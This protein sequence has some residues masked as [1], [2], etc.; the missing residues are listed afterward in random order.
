MANNCSIK[1]IL[2]ISILL[3]SIIPLEYNSITNLQEELSDETIRP[4]FSSFLY[5]NQTSYYFDLGYDF[6]HSNNRAFGTFSIGNSLNNTTVL[7]SFQNYN[8][9]TG[10]NYGVKSFNLLSNQS[11]GHINQ[12]SGYNSWTRKHFDTNDNGSIFYRAHRYYGSSTNN[13]FT[14]GSTYQNLTSYNSFQTQNQNL[15]TYIRNPTAIDG[16]E[17]YSSSSSTTYYYNQGSSY[18]RETTNLHAGN[19]S[20]SYSSCATGFNSGAG[21]VVKLVAVN[22]SAI[23][24]QT[25]QTG[26]SCPDQIHKVNPDLGTLEWSISGTSGY[27]WMNLVGFDPNHGLIVSND[28]TSA[29]Y[30]WNTYDPITGNK[31]N[32][33]YPNNLS[34]YIDYDGALDYVD[35]AGRGY[36]QNKIF[37]L[38]T[39]SGFTLP[40]HY[41]QNG[42]ISSLGTILR[43]GAGM[44]V[45]VMHQNGTAA[46][47]IMDGDEDGVL[48]Y[49]FATPGDQCLDSPFTING[50]DLD[51]DGCYSFEDLDDD[52]DTI[53]DSIDVCVVISTGVDTD[54]DGC[55]DIFDSDD[56]NDG[57]EDGNESILG[58]DPLIYDTDWDGVCDG[59]ISFFNCTAGPDELPLEPTQ[60]SDQ[61]EDGW[62]DNPLG[63]NPDAF[64]LD[65]NATSDLDGDGMPDTIYGNSTTGLIEDLDDDGDGILDIYETGTGVYNGTTDMGTDSLDP[66]TDDDNVNDGVDLAPLDFE[67]SGPDTDGDGLLDNI[68]DS[69]LYYYYYPGYDYLSDNYQNGS[70]WYTAVF[71]SNETY[72]SWTDGSTWS[73]PKN[74]YS[75]MVSRAYQLNTILSG[76]A[77]LNFRGAGTYSISYNWTSATCNFDLL[78]NG[79][80]LSPSLGNHTLLGS[81]GFGNNS[82][83]FSI[84]ELNQDDCD[85]NSVEIIDFQIPH[86]EITDLGLVP[87][88]DDDND[89]FSDRIEVEGLCNG[90]ISDPLSNLS[91]PPDMD[92]DLICDA[93]DDDIDGD[94]FNNSVDVF[95]LDSNDWEDLDGDGEG[96]NADVDDDG[97][98]FN[99]SVDSWPLG[100]CVSEDYDSDGL[101]D[102]IVMNCNTVVIEDFDDDN[103]NKLDQDDFCSKGDLNWLSGAVTDHDQ[104]GCQDSGEDLDDDNDGLED[105]NDLCPKGHVGWISNPSADADADGCHD[106]IEDND[107]DNDGVTEPGDLCP[108]TPANV[109][110]DANGCPIDLDGDGVPDYLDN[111]PNTMLGIQVDTNGCPIDSDGDGVPDFQDDFP[112]DANETIDSDGDGVGDNADAFPNDPN[113]TMDSDGD[114]Y[115][116]NADAFPNNALEFSDL[117]GDGV[118]GNTDVFPN[119]ANETLDSDLDEVGDNSDVFPNDANETMDSDGDGVGDNSDVFPDD[120]SETTDSDGDGVGDTSD[121]FPT[122]ANETVDSDGDGI[123]DSKDECL[124]Q[125]SEEVGAD[126]C[127]IQ[128]STSASSNLEGGLAI[129]VLLVVAI[130]G[131]VVGTI[132]MRKKEEFVTEKIHPHIEE[133][134]SS[135][136]NVELDYSQNPPQNSEGVLGDDGYHWLE[137]PQ[138]SGTWY[139]RGTSNDQWTLFEQ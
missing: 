40:Y 58:S 129:G 51:G 38:A 72:W 115:G 69:R 100:N 68:S 82:L 47:H 102:Y 77:E 73:F 85:E 49:P 118:G 92:G 22:K 19:F 105:G 1:S 87:D 45:L 31:T 20:T 111:C 30:H 134:I 96:N 48:S 62:G 116:D 86:G 21:K 132:F 55:Q 34:Q 64:P 117:D 112:Y 37:Y 101:A 135:P 3:L 43:F 137:W 75:L 27:G 15:P 94:G 24:Y 25:D 61:D 120:A 53:P 39:A 9:S 35:D 125:N 80:S 131:I 127:A 67:A 54:Q 81:L 88:F 91:T 16:I 12:G 8:T 66:D 107:D 90:S 63:N 2:L 52:N 106:F 89:G 71:L 42:D 133:E 113:E 74:N 26:G 70:A 65:P 6:S 139:Y 11:V 5:S 121:V 108:N 60:W 14:M 136:A 79:V 122:D 50:T 124:T 44:S 10:Y 93:W 128:I 33:N 23:F 17:V 4:S 109:T 78:L 46:L 99:D 138:G 57:I 29:N 41:V 83:E 130:V 114:G 36:Y 32:F 110:V 84:V 103:D 59:S 95:P 76:S 13:Y 7:I 119:D 123:G 18:S 98:G 97:D 126:G 104:D 56:D 28:S